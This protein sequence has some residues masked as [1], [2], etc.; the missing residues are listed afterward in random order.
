LCA[1]GNVSPSRD[2]PIVGT[3]YLYDAEGRRVAKGTITQATCDRTTNGFQ[4]TS[5]YI[6]DQAGQQVSELDGQGNWQHT[7]VYLGGQLLA[8]YDPQGL[9][10]SSTD[11]LGTK[12]VQAS[13]TG[14]PELNCASML[15]GDGDPC[16]VLQ[17]GEATEHRFTGKERDTES[18]LDNSSAR[19]YGSSMGRFMSP[20]FTG[21]GSDPVPV[22]SADFEN[23][24][25]LNLYSYVHNS[26][27]VNVDPDGHDCVVQT[28]TT[29]TTES[30]SVSS[31]NCDNVKVGDG[32][33]KSYVAGTVTSICGAGSSINV[34]CTPYA[35]G[36]DAG[37]ANLNVASTPDRPGLAYNYGNNAQGYQMLGAADKAVTYG[38]YAYADIFG[39]VGAAI[40]G[41]EIAAG[42][43]AARSQ[44]IFRL[45]HGMQ[46]VAG[47]SRVLA[48]VG[49]VKNAI[50]A[51]VASGAVTSLG[52]NAFQ[53]VVNVAG[54]YIRFTGATTPAGT[55]ISNVMGAALQR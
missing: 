41:G 11:A 48:D 37:V 9:H 21:V 47:H 17:G 2:K 54:T 33:T 44:I 7:N 28:R 24:Q 32:Q 14:V 13:A 19:H 18:G 34:G 1:V 31:G 55:V 36:G 40:A 50:A 30:V 20:D 10:F 46:I 27:L 38:T 4:P 5:T 35:G 16:T 45:A 22:P 29:E 25:S 43:A 49:A 12:R 39:S 15:F 3:Q 53:G 52:G 23:P 26:P 51:A 42:T 6:L 8:T